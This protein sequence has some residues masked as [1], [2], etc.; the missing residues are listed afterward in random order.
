MALLFGSIQQA[1]LN[2]AWLT[3][4][5]FDG[6]HIGH[7]EIIRGLAVGARAQGVPVVV[8]TFHPHPA[9][10]VRQLGGPHLLTMPDERADY[11][12]DVGADVVITQ[13]FDHQIAGTDAEEFLILLQK[14]LGFHHLWVGYDFA[15]GHKRGGD[16]HRLQELGQKLGFQLK[17]IPAVHINGQIVSS[18]RIRGMLREGLV[19][20][21]AQALGR[22]Y[23][24]SG[25]VVVGDRRG[26]T[27][28]FPTANLSL[29]AEKF[30]PQSGVYACLAHWNGM[31]RPAA[32]NIGLRPTFDGSSATTQIEAHI[33]DFEGDLY[34]HQLSLYFVD[35]LR[36]EKGFPS[37]QALI[38]QIQQDI[39]QTR[40]LVKIFQPAG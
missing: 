6:V 10:V 29:P 38:E 8:L 39:D 34:G 37:T 19:S 40:R 24:I 22:W 13:P 2:D 30:I 28:G 21:A 5:T 15:L 3:I 31:Q 20:Q 11:L 33:L 14:H 35:R 12:S 7:Q 16:I 25:E 9:A 1:S 17:V 23:K 26:H 18:S 4:G 32:V 36:D 27:L